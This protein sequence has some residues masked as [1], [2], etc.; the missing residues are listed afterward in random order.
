MLKCHFLQRSFGRLP[1]FGGPGKTPHREGEFVQNASTGVPDG[2]IAALTSMV[3]ITY[4]KKLKKCLKLDP[5]CP[6]AAEVRF[7]ALSPEKTQEK[8]FNCLEIFWR[9]RCRFFLGWAE[10]GLCEPPLGCGSP[11]G[12]HCRDIPSSSVRGCKT[13]RNCYGQVA[14]RSFMTDNP[15]LGAR[16]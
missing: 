13:M 15:V 9:N 12:F 11:N 16:H 6:K 14:C 1:R 8:C 7:G 4:D 3:P 10:V 5:R 2:R